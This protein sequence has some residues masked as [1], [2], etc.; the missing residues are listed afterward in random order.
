MDMIVGLDVVVDEQ[1]YKFDLNIRGYNHSHLLTKTITLR[2]TVKP[3]D[4]YNKTVYANC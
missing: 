4:N 1:L 3:I 2:V